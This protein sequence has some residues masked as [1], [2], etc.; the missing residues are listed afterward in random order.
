[1]L[2]RVLSLAQEVLVVFDLLFLE[3]LHYL[4]LFFGEPVE[5]WDRPFVLLD[6]EL[7]HLDRL[8]MRSD[9]LL[10]LG[11]SFLG[12]LEFLK[13]SLLGP[14]GLCWLTLLSLQGNLQL[15]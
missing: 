5:L 4:P 10:D 15:G 7:V 13:L 14:L 3:Q 8:L 6:G 11:L 12:L 2:A 1:L 9:L